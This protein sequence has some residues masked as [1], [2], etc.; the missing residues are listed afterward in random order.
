[1]S[2]KYYVIIET[3][4]ITQDMIDESL[5]KEDTMRFSLD[6]TCAILKFENHFPNHM[7][8]YIKYSHD[9][10]LEYLVTNSAEW[11]SAV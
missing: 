11:D 9:G 8:G 1:M 5:N 6:C 4:N 10:M 3:T 2:H 7:A